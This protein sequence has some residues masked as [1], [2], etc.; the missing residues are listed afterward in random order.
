MVI[1]SGFD[2]GVSDAAAIDNMAAVPIDPNSLPGGTGDVYDPTAG[3]YAT[4][5]DGSGF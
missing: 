4:I 2:S 5:S 1:G 3:L